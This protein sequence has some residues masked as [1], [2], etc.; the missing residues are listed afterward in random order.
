MLRS[1]AYLL[2]LIKVVE[3]LSKVV[4]T[5]NKNLICSSLMNAFDVWRTRQNL[6]LMSEIGVS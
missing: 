2:G 6:S 1:P 4:E 3:V 5:K